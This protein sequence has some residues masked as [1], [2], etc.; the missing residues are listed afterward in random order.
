MAGLLLR[1]LVAAGY[2]W[3]LV[4]VGEEPQLAPLKQHLAPLKQHLARQAS[5]SST[6]SPV[7]AGDPGRQGWGQ[8]GLRPRS[9]RL[10]CL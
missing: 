5:H 3:K 8:G 4:R 1:Q 9:Q 10:A 2:S 7:A 6:G